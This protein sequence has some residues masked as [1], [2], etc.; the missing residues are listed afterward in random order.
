MKFDFEEIRCYKNEE[1]HDALKRLCSEKAFMKV[2]ST[3]YPLM[4]KDIIKDR[5]DNFHSNYEFQKEIVY[6]F[7]QYLEANKTKGIDL[8]G[9]NKIDPSKSYLYIS[10]HRDIILDSAFLCGKFIERN[11]DTVEIAIGDNLLI[12]PWIED[13]VRINKSF[14]VKR[15]L[16][17]RQIL[18]SSQRLSAYI[19]HTINAKNQSIW[20]AQREGRAKDSNDRTQESL[21][22]MFNMNGDGNF[23]EN[24]SKLNICPLSISYEYDPCD[25]LKAKEMQQKR[26]NP[27]F[28]KNPGDDLLNMETG[29]MGYK[30]K[31]VYE[32]T[33]P[34]D[35]ELRIIAS[36]TTNRSEQIT[37]TAELIDKRIHANYT[38]F[39]NNKIAYD[40][41]KEEGQRFVDQYTESERDDFERYLKF[42]ISKIDLADKD[43]RFLRLKLIE[44]YAN[45]LVNK[46]S[47]IPDLGQDG[48]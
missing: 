32:I 7:L 26:D 2:L 4:P 16:S 25:F 48:D 28:V 29:V 21:L 19:E 9:L 47:T 6:P 35:K 44:M 42:Q 13:L 5:L 11:M 37:L 18:E 15:G 39:T 22:K 12:F 3:I 14:I 31:V 45:P 20:I 34:I 46:L 40:T 27:D 24:I 41:L 8:N 36:Q 38:T 43:E 23:I 33:G 10:N 1:V 30:G 17:S